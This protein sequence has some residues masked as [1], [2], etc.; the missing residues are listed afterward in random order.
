MGGVG[1][2]EGVGGREGFRG[3]RDEDGPVDRVGFL[4]V[5]GVGGE[6]DVEER[7]GDLGGWDGGLGG[8]FVRWGFGM[9]GEVGVEGCGMGCW[10]LFGG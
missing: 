3:G 5:V 7:V 2:Q 4:R 9:V 1:V 10:L 6:G 8:H